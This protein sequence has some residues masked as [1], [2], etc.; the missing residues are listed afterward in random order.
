MFYA[1]KELINLLRGSETTTNPMHIANIHLHLNDIN[2]HSAKARA[3]KILS[4]PG[5]DHH[6]HQQPYPLFLVDGAC[7]LHWQL[8]FLLN[9]IFY[10]SMNQQIILILIVVKN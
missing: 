7:V 3:S 2:T 10:C 6:T 5:F 8:C 9:L 4:D 1:D